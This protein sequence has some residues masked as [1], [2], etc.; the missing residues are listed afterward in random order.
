MANAGAFVTE[1]AVL[2]K[3]CGHLLLV[4]GLGVCQ[5][6]DEPKPYSIA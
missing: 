5:R 6:K 1:A 2:L 3:G 4:A